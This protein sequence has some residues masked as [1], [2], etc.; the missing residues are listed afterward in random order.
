M[1]KK[2]CGKKHIRSN[3]EDDEFVETD[4][5][6]QLTTE[7]SESK[8]YD[9]LYYKFILLFYRV[10]QGEVSQE[11]IDGANTAE[12][13][14]NNSDMINESICSNN[15]Y[16]NST[17]N[18]SINHITNNYYIYVFKDEPI[19]SFL[20]KVLIAYFLVQLIS[21]LFENNS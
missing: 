7:S 10:V 9:I 4:E 2:S 18:H 1:S 21:S 6:V 16:T 12:N 11:T 15:T 14:E 5:S 17:S 13:E 19:I 8:C 20:A 3:H